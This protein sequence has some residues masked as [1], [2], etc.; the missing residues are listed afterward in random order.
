MLCWLSTPTR[1]PSEPATS[2]YLRSSS[3]PDGLICKKAPQTFSPSARTPPT[4]YETLTLPQSGYDPSLTISEPSQHAY[5]IL[6]LCRI[7]S[8][9]M[10]RINTSFLILEPSYDY[11]NVGT[12]IHAHVFQLPRVPAPKAS[13]T[14]STK[15]HSQSI[16]MIP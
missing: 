3:S 14:L 8:T 15:E 16:I 9:A 2:T 13:R 7:D 1:Y 4:N 11:S 10:L 6:S 5:T 12:W